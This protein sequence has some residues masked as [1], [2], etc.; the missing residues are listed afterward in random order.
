MTGDLPRGHLVTLPRSKRGDRPV[1][2][3]FCGFCFFSRP[4]LIAEAPRRQRVKGT[5]T[6]SPRVGTASGRGPPRSAVFDSVGRTPRVGGASRTST[7]E[8]VLVELEVF[9]VVPK[10]LRGA[11]SEFTKA[12]QTVMDMDMWPVCLQENVRRTSLEVCV[13]GYEVCPATLQF[14]L[15]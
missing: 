10:D 12:V 8:P 1:W 13:L 9:T 7:T 4:L 14:Y 3:G 15:A 2:V 5:P 11:T 6:V